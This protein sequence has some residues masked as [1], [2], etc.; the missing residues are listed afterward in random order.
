[1][2]AAASRESQL[3]GWEAFF[4]KFMQ[5]FF[6]KTPVNLEIAQKIMLIMP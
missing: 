5:F 4:T 1:M 6:A 3:W 2:A